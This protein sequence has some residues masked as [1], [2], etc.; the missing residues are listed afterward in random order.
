VLEEILAEQPWLYR[1]TTKARPLGEGTT[2]E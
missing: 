1:P 2:V